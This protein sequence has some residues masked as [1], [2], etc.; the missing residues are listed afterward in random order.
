MKYREKYNINICQQ[1]NTIQSKKVWSVVERRATKILN[2]H[3]VC[4][5]VFRSE[6]QRTSHVNKRNFFSLK[7]VNKQNCIRNQLKEIKNKKF[8]Q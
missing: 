7:W 5:K 3:G 8:T 2:T 6:A 1:R 4:S